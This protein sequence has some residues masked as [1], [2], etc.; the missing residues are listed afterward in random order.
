MLLF[1]L[2]TKVSVFKAIQAKV[3]FKSLTC[4]HFMTIC[5]EPAAR[6]V[7]ELLYGAGAGLQQAGWNHQ[8]QRPS[9]NCQ[10]IQ[11]LLSRESLPGVHHVS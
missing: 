7:G 5:V 8:S 2:S 6:C 1:S 4:E 10:G 9:P 3:T 11:Q